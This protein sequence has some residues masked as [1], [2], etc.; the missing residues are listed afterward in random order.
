MERN[1]LK[2]QKSWVQS[3]SCT[4]R[5]MLA[6]VWTVTKKVNKGAWRMPWVL[7]AKKDVISCDKPGGS[8]NTIWSRRFPNGATRCIEDASPSNRSKPAELKHLSKQRRRKQFSDCASSG[9]RTRISPNQVDYGQSG[10]IGLQCGL[11]L[12]NRTG[13]ERP[14]IEG[15]SPVYEM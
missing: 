1:H 4:L 3:K 6:R 11:K 14:T 2:K 9:E 5:F 10:V 12:Y 7:E 15:D 8:A 13:L